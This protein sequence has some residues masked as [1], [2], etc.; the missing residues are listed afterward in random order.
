MSGAPRQVERALVVLI[1]VHSYAVGLALVFATEWG[2]RLGGW[3]RVAPLFFARQAGVF[4]LVVATGYLLEYSR[5]RGVS[6]L[7]VTKAI[8]VVFLFSSTALGNVPWVVPFSGVVDGLMG[9]TVAL[10]RR[11]DAATQVP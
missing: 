2:A 5:D 8:A 10:V 3:D 9:A 11:A 4:H 6:L 7:L 1:A